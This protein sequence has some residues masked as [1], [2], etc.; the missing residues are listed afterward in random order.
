MVAVRHRRRR[1][2]PAFRCPTFHRSVLHE[3]DVAVVTLGKPAVL[4]QFAVAAFQ[5]RR[6]DV[7][8]IRRSA[9][10][11]QAG[12]FLPWPG[13][14][15][16]LG[17]FQWRSCVRLLENPGPTPFPSVRVR[18]TRND[19]FRAQAVGKSMLSRRFG[20]P[21]G[22][23]A[24]RHDPEHND[25]GSIYRC[26]P[27]RRRYVA[28]WIKPRGS[29]CTG[30]TRVPHRSFGGSSSSTPNRS[31]RMPSEPPGQEPLE[32]RPDLR[33]PRQR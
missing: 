20:Y 1:R 11:R 32:S 31:R 16:G 26:I 14:G 5:H 23:G 30:S 19:A 27:N 9:F 29:W 12:D 6:R 24:G 18:L 17:V 8:S 2:G 7:R 13:S 10:G 22:I 28:P 4:A 21:T 15:R 25:G 3:V 33:V